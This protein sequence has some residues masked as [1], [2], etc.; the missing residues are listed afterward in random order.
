[1]G[2]GVPRRNGAQRGGGIATVGA[3][4]CDARW[5]AQARVAAFRERALIASIALSQRAF[6]R[7]TYIENSPG[8]P[9]CH[10]GDSCSIST[11]G[12]CGLPM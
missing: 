2:N 4:A 3:A 10:C 12:P 5:M 11:T 9:A 7:L 6:A 8:A 1:M